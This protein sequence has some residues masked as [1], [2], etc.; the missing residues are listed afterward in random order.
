MYKKIQ[1]ILFLTSCLTFIFLVTKHY[2]SEENILRTNKSRTSYT[3]MINEY[4]EIFT[5]IQINEIMKTIK[6]IKN[7]NIKE[8]PTGI[9]I[10]NALKWC[11]LYSL[12]I[13][14]D[15]IYLN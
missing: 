14:K 10:R 13:N 9:Q 11:E 15:C 4:N 8:Y 1:N 6:N 12:P 5:D 7:K 2:F 3:L